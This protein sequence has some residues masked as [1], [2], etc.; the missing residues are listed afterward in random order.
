MLDGDLVRR[1]ERTV[2]GIHPLVGGY[3]LRL[4]GMRGGLGMVRDGLKGLVMSSVTDL[5]G[6]ARQLRL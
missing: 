4:S 1:S 3:V 5:M 6:S 2:R